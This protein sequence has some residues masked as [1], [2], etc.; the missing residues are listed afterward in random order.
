M[1]RMVKDDPRSTT[2]RN[3]RFLRQKTLM[4]QAESYSS[5]RV[6]DALGMQK[7]PEHEQWRLGLLTSLLNM[8][9]DRHN[10]VLDSKQLCGMI[11]SLSST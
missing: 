6:K 11:D 5:W 10:R 4:Q 7:V 9:Q 1:A 8:R 2:C 3:L